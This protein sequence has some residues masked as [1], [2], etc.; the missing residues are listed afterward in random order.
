MNKFFALCGLA[1][2]F[3]GAA[4]TGCSNTADGVS[5]DAENAGTAVKEGADRVAS[6][7]EKA[8]E[9]AVNAGK[10]AGENVTGAVQVTPDVKAALLADSELNNTANKIDVDTADKVVHLKGHVMSNELKKKAGEIAEKTIKDAGGT[11][12]VMNE[13]VVEKH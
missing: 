2:L 13:L 3:G 9:D 5:K 10:K 7:T 1:A 6:A 4:L 8:T 12:T 11:D